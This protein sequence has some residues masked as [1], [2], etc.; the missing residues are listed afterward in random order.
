[1]VSGQIVRFGRERAAARYVERGTHAPAV[2]HVARGRT[3]TDRTGPVVILDGRV[4]ARERA[5]AERGLRGIELRGGVT[6]DGDRPVG[7][8]P[9][10]G[11][12][13]IRLEPPEERQH[14]REAPAR[15]A[16]ARPA[17]VHRGCAAQ[18]EARIR[19]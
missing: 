2:A 18:R 17:V 8:V 13:G 4:P 12:V 9:L 11:E 19:R 14:F 5:L 7:A 10:V 3:G 16:R 1:M 6:A 15:V